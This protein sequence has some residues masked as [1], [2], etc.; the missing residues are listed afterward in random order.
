MD[1]KALSKEAREALLA[2][3]LGD[4]STP[5]ALGEVEFAP[6]VKT[7]TGGG[8]YIS[9]PGAGSINLSDREAASFMLNAVEVARRVAA[10]V[11]DTNATG[12][13][14]AHKGETPAIVAKRVATI[15]AAAKK[16]LADLDAAEGK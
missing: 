1:I 11:V 14:R 4:N 9:G 13:G 5:E 16:V 8:I 15:K 2:E 6:Q 10:H 3:L 12:I 7:N